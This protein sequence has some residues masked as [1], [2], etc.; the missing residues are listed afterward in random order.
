LGIT[1]LW[2][3]QKSCV[4]RPDRVSPFLIQMIADGAAGPIA[5]R[6]K[7]RTQ[8][9]HYDSVRHRQRTIGESAEMIRRGSVDVMTMGLGQPHGACDGGD[10]CDDCAVDTQRGARKGLRPFDMS[11]AALM[12]MVLNVILSR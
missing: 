2:N 7:A 1:T 12:E 6:I 11:A 4:T 9:G 10:E 5:I 3:K 8:H